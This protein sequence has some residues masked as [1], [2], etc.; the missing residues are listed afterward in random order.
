[1]QNKVFK[2]KISAKQSGR[3]AVVNDLSSFGKCSLTASLPIF[4][5]MGLQACPLPTAVLSCQTGF[6]NFFQ[7]DMT[8]VWEDFFRSWQKMGVVFDG[9]ISCFA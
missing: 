2:N 3:V 1:M 7:Q 6:E 4:S 5:C 9:I 8:F